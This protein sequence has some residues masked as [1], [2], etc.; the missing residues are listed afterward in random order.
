VIRWLEEW[1]L[2]FGNKTYRWPAS[3]LAAV[4]LVA[5]ACLGTAREGKSAPPQAKKA[6]KK[7]AKS[8]PS[9]KSKS[10]VHHTT[11]AKTKKRTTAKARTTRRRR[12]P[13]G[14][15]ARLALLHLDP[16]RVEEIQQALIREGVLSGTPSSTWDNS[17]KSAMRQYQ[18]ENGF[19]ETGLPDAKSLMKLGLGP[20][21][22]PMDVQAAAAANAEPRMDSLAHPTSSS[23]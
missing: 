6:S 16:S 22:L 20:H 13:R 1:G 18:S 17:T 12:L 10:T 4:L 14:S 11:S 15:R 8:V 23:Q 5:V 21:P 19:S 3:A 7:K 2:N 9:T